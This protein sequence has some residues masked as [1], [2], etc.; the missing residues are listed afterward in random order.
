MNKQRFTDRPTSQS[1][2]H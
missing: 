2:C 1:K